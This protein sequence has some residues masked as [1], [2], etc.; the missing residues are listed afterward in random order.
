M[1]SAVKT[2][3]LAYALIISLIL[4]L[5]LSLGLGNRN[6][7]NRRA[8]DYSITP[9]EVFSTPDD[10]L[11]T[12][13][14]NTIPVVASQPTPIPLQSAEESGPE[15]EDVLLIY[16]QGSL[17]YFSTNFC[18]LVNFY[19]LTC[20]MVSV[21]S[22][23][24]SD[25]LLRDSQGDYFKL[26]G[27][28]AEAIREGSTLFSEEELNLLKRIVQEGHSDLFISKISDRVDESRL[29]LLTDGSIN[30]VSNP[31]DLLRDWIV[32]ST[33]PEITR[34][35]SGQIIVTSQSTAPFNYSLIVDDTEGV[36]NLITSSDQVGDIYPIFVRYKREDIGSGE[37]GSVFLDAGELGERADEIPLRELVYSAA[38]FTQIIP[39]MMTIRYSMG[40]EVWH[41]DHN[42][43]NLTIDRGSL[44]E[45]TQG[46]DFTVL[47][48][49]MKT[50]NF[51][52]TV[53]LIPAN[54]SLSSPNVIA[55]FLVNPDR[56][57][58]VQYGNNADGYEFYFYDEEQVDQSLSGT[59]PPRPMEEQKWNIME[60]LARM[61]MH[62][63]LTR[64][65]YEKVMIFPLGL[66]PE[67]TLEFLKQNNY[68]ATVSTQ[69]IPLGEAPPN[70]LNFGMF[71]AIMDFGNFPILTHR[72]PSDSNAF[73]PS[74][75]LS[76]MDLFLD[77]P[78]LFYTYPYGEGLYPGDM[79]VFNPIADQLNELPGGVE[80]RGL[81]YILLHLYLEKTNDDGSIDISMYTNRVIIQNQQL[82][83][84]TYH[85]TKPEDLNV[86]ILRVTVNGY[87]FPYRVEDNSLSLDVSI[88]SGVSAEI[89]IEYENGNP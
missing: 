53:A 51:H 1:R 70:N 38:R 64:I 34:E 18:L 27:L 85:V 29:A 35:F 56:Y 44:A 40:D 65:P 80:W 25:N 39:L 45:S 5:G 49:F 8:L 79:D 31:D 42:F 78:A 22:Q 9:V 57:S 4:G 88:P 47:L 86:P 16:D 33:D 3:E 7:S 67:P 43:A 32:S 69:D 24:L 82:D 36:S 71:P 50:H 75:L 48:Q 58:L 54:W 74:L 52:T 41:N 26:I 60:G 76:L 28:D 15:I 81:G 89:A 2:R 66:S 21:D 14:A 12:P 83:T 62:R 72:F 13:S 87:E 20:K 77:K 59:L 30:G 23:N 46:L 6:S 10:L 55:L 68:L 17:S 11:I 63:D 84:K 73:Q 61:E 19:G 37:S